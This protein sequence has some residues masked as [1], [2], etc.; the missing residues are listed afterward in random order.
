MNTEIHLLSEPH[1]NTPLDIKKDL[2]L[3]EY[4]A[5]RSEILQRLSQRQELLTYTLIGAA[6]FLGIGVQPGISGVTVLCYP[7]LSFFLALAW[8]QHDSRIGQINAFL[9]EMED[10][11]LASLGPGWETHRRAL[12]KKNRRLAS[13][14]SLPARGLFIGSQLLAI[15]VGC[16]RFAE[17]PTMIPVFVLL[18]AVSC[19]ASLATLFVLSSRRD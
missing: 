17:A 18:L 5:L 12:W 15:I 13:I 9:R 10:R 6:S 4:A 11:H 8:A 16:A 7:T 3:S 19:I 2:L 1:P 14:V